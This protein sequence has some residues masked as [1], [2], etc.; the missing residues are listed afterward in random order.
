TNSTPGVSIDEVV[1]H[2]TDDEAAAYP[3]DYLEVWKHNG[4]WS[5]TGATLDTGANTLTLAGLNPASDYGILRGNASTNIS[6][7]FEINETGE[8]L[9]TD[10]LSGSLGTGACINVTADDVTLD[11]DGHT[12]SDDGTGYGVYAG[13]V[14]NFYLQNCIVV[15]YSEGVSLYAVS[16][17]ELVNISSMDS[18][19][20]YRIDLSHD[21]KITD[22]NSKRGHAVIIKRSQRVHIDPSYFC[23][24]DYGL[25]LN[26]SNDTIIEDTVACNNSILGIYVLDSDNTTIL[27]SRTYNN[28]L[29]FQAENNL[30]GPVDLTMTSLVFDRPAGDMADYTDLHLIDSLAS[31]E[32]LAISWTA[33]A[34]ALP[35]GYVSF[36]D[37]FV[38]ISSTGSPSITSVEWHWTDSE[39]SSGDYNESSLDIFEWNGT[40][41]TD[42]NATLDTGANTLT[43][44]SFTPSSDYGILGNT[45]PYA[46]AS[47]Y[48]VNITNVTRLARYNHTA[49]GNASTAGGNI[50]GSNLSSVQLTERWAGFYGDVVGTIWLTGIAGSSYLYSWEW[51]AAEGGV[52]CLSTNGSLSDFSALGATGPDIDS[53]WMFSQNA[54]DSGTNTFANTNCSLQLGPSNLTGA[55]YAD[56]G[57]AGGYITCALKTSSIPAKSNLIFCS[58]IIDSGT[59]WDGSTVD[60]EVM[61]PTPIGPGET[62]TYYFYANLN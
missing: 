3:E 24:S 31:G 26:L 33:N 44:G 41:W 50:T 49:A 54:S 38:D 48:G 37:K 30:A 46:N 36:E 56:T 32:D 42:M 35:P 4:T 62:E 11:C 28:A 27:N 20:N 10:D 19:N 2:W 15:N 17:G 57:P 43:L 58:E 29:D 14:S 61:V 18:N 60:Y 12:I 45:T 6:T 51:S 16:S 9:L 52:V 8:Y 1:W 55:S 21:V 22:S 59:A 5:N 34:T 25:L 40:N 23:N 53:A 7:C 47:L 39:V 13:S